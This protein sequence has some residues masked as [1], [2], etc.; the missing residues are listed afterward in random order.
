MP[1][2]HKHG[3]FVRTMKGEKQDIFLE[4]LPQTGFEPVRQTAGI[5]KRHALAIASRTS[6]IDIHVTDKLARG[7]LD[8]RPLST[9][10]GITTD[11]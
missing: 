4:N 9:E 7:W 1:K 2:G 3:N 6:H 11:Y 5:A 10:A 8:A